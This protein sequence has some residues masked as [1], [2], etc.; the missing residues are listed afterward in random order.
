MTTERAFIQQS[1]MTPSTLSSS[2]KLSSVTAQHIKTIEKIFFDAGLGERASMFFVP[3]E[4][5]LFNSA[6]E[7][8]ASTN[9]LRFV[10][11]SFNQA[12]ILRD[13]SEHPVL[14]ETLVLIFGVSQYFSDILIRDPELFRWLTATAVL[15][16]SRTKEEFL[17]ASRQSIEPFQS[18]SRKL[19]VL[20]RF[21]RREMLRI[22]V[23]DILGLAD[24]E[25]TMRELSHL[26]DAVTVRVAELSWTELKNQFGGEPATAWAIIGLGKLGGE[27]LNY[28]SDIDLMAVYDEDG[29]IGSSSSFAMTHGEFFVR[30]VEL[31]VQS[32]SHPTE[33]GYFYRVDMR[34]RPDGK[35]GA[36]IRS[37]ESAV[38]YYESRGE[39]WERQMLIK[40]RYISGGKIFAQKFLSALSPFIYPRT[41]FQNP[42]EEISRIK[43]R[44]ES[45]SDERNI[46]LRAGGIRDIEFIVQALQL[47]NGGKNA[48]LRTSNTLAAVTL[49]HSMHLLSGREA[50]Q[51][52][53]AY[54]FFRI[55]EHRLQM[56]A[57]A[58]THSLPEAARE[59]KK[60]ALRMA[61]PS[62]QF[63]KLLA[64]H[65]LNVRRIFKTVFTKRDFGRHSD[66]ELFLNEKPGS[67]FSQSF[68]GRYRL[69]NNEKT[70]RTLRRMLYGTNLLGK[71]E[72]PERTRTLFKSVAEPLLDEISASIA[73]DQALAHCERILSSFPSP[74]AMYSLCA[75]KNF[76]RSFITICAHSGMLARQF[77]L[78]PGLAEQ[79]L[80]SV[81]TVLR[82]D[83]V[84]APPGV[85]V[86]LWKAVEECKLAVRYI[87]GTIDEYALFRSLS[88]IASSALSFLYEQERKKL[89]IAKG[90]RF[91]IVGMGKL[92]GSEM[93][94]GS[95]LD[96]VF[97]FEA[98][99]KQDAEKCERLASNIMTECS[100]ASSAGKL[101][102]IDARLRPEGRNAPLAV[103]RGQYFE[104]LNERASLWER[105]SLTRARTISGD[106]DFSAEMMDSIRGSI[107]QS[108]LPEGW[109]EE[110]LAMRRK[111][112]SRSRTSSSEFLDIKLGAGGLMDAEFAVQALQLSRRKNAYAMTNVY[113]LLEQYA[114]G[115]SNSENIA[116]IGN[117][118]RLLRR[119]ETALRLG[120]DVRNHVVP[121]DEDSLDY[122][123]RL[124]K[125]PAGMEM[126]S[127]LRASMKETR[128]L[129]ESILESLA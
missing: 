9:F 129:F 40:A 117:H 91:C 86:H 49:L 111:T 42:I 29:E 64:G 6:D 109:T 102:D 59:R 3:L 76:R 57:Y 123:A 120:L 97:L 26:A 78:S 1:S 46:K 4:K 81:E 33:E 66:V 11:S 122:L 73:P 21:Q 107:Y 44:I 27:E 47:L 68:A 63:E 10:E 84:P 103:A 61:I 38:L 55:L 87:L 67:D 77:A 8:M 36:L 99:R 75:E 72:F 60:I 127:S 88:D 69:G 53:E 121:A 125:Y 80:T 39:L 25:T 104:Y 12:A 7:T 89:K 118:Y 48:S 18:H 24:L 126:L 56:L 31:V 35:A 52:R 85:S 94:F 98:K 71:K 79:V 65:L 14:L 58:Q 34:L 93:N 54:C 96:V 113:D 106:K 32:L 128:S 5:Q 16:Q 95:D 13:L 17:N 23:R 114:R 112:E 22:G 90:V 92:G 20:K 45:N 15:D 70:I 82:E 37:F 62:D 119:V 19:N 50:A 124:L 51:L 74:D 115:L 43:A 100:R 83:V 108:P 2:H 30:F 105:Q 101:Y 28:S 41:F 116:I 110:I